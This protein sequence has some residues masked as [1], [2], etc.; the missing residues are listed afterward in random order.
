MSLTKYIHVRG[1]ELRTRY[2]TCVAAL[3]CDAD[4]NLLIWGQLF[5]IAIAM[6]HDKLPCIGLQ[7]NPTAY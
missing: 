3:S 2:V 7:I 6:I 1:A 4:L 5:S